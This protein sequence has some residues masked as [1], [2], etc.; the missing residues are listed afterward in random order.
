MSRTTVSYSVV[1]V[2]VSAETVSRVGSEGRAT[3]NAALTPITRSVCSQYINERTVASSTVAD[4]SSMHFRR[5]EEIKR[6]WWND[7]PSL[8][9]DFDS[10]CHSGAEACLPFPFEIAPLPLTPAACPLVPFECASGALAPLP[11]TIA[12]RSG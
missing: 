3:L 11:S 6:P 10:T 1:S 5:R 7:R 2:C 12:S 9:P 8:R 4:D